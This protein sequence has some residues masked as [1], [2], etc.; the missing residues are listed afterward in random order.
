[1]GATYD[2]IL[3]VLEQRGWSRL[4]ERVKLPKWKKLWLACRYGLF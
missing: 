3:S 2:A 4:D 1:M